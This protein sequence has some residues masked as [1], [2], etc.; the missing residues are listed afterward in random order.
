MDGER[1]LS[2]VAPDVG[3]E[4][5]DHLEK[6]LQKPGVH[7]GVSKKSLRVLRD[8]YPNIDERIFARKVPKGINDFMFRVENGNLEPIVGMSRT[9]F[10]RYHVDDMLNA[11]NGLVREEGL[12]DASDRKSL[13]KLTSDLKEAL[14]KHIKGQILPEEKGQYYREMVPKMLVGLVSVIG[15]LVTGLITFGQHPLSLFDSLYPKNYTKLISGKRR[16][17][18]GGKLYVL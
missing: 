11:L 6:I 15:Y 9:D 16:D 12:L 10:F 17:G 5:A 3:I 4:H 18:Y 1:G 7:V 8:R 2:A 14:Q 13:G